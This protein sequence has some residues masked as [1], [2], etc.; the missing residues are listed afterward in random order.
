MA[1]FP[2]L[3]RLNLN[4][5]QKIYSPYGPRPRRSPRLVK[6]WIAALVLV[7]LLTYYVTS[8]HRETTRAYASKLTRGRGWEED[9]G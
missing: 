8:R 5:T 4:L 9:R 2:R 3:P 7:G 1:F 6:A